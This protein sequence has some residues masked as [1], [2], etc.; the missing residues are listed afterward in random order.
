M[1]YKINLYK[2]EVFGFVL[3]VIVK[4]KILKKKKKSLM[5]CLK[6]E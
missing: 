3:N 6:Y 1:Q 5:R 4:T 2:L